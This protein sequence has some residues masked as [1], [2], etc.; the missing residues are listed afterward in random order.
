MM[1]ICFFIGH[2]AFADVT[3]DFTADQTTI[4]AGTE[5]Q[6]TD[7]SIGNP[8]SWQWD[9]ENDG[10]IDSYEQNPEWTYEEPGLFT[11]SLTVSD[12]T[13]SDTETKTD[14]I[15]VRVNIPDANFKAKI[16]S[17]LGQPP[18]YNPTVADLNGITGYFFAGNSNISSIEGVQYLTNIPKLFLNKNQ[19]SDISA[20]SGLTNLISLD[21]EENQII[22]ISA[23]S[24]LTNLTSL[25]LDKNQ[26]SDISAISGLT[27]LSNLYLNDNQISDIS[28]ISGL[29]NLFG[30]SLYYNQ[31]SDISVIS[32]LTNLVSLYLGGNQISDISAI[33]GLTNLRLLYLA[34]NQ[35][36]DISAVS[37]LTNLEWLWL[38]QNQISDIS[39]V[40][41]LMNL[42]YLYLNENQISDISAVSGLTN[43]NFLFLNSN[44][45]SD[46]SAFS[47]LTNLAS[48]YLYNNQISD[49]SVV[50]GLTNLTCF[51]LSNN[52]ISDISTVSGLTNLFFIDLSY[53]QIND[54]SA[55]SSLPNMKKL[56]LGGN[57]IID[58]ATISSLTNLTELSLGGNHISDISAVSG[59]TNLRE[60][61]LDSN[62]ISDIYPLVE[63]TELGSGD[64]LQL[65]SNPL[66]LE[67]LIVHIPI[68]EN[69]GF[70]TLQFPSTPN[71][72][73]ACYPDPARYEVGVSINADLEWQGNFPSRDAV[74]DVWLGETSDDLVNVG[75][76]TAI[77]DTLYSFTP[78]L[79]PDTVYW[80]K[81][82]AI[83]ATD[84]I[85]SGLWRFTTYIIADFSADQT[86]IVAGD[87]IQFTDLSTG[88]PTNWEWDFEN[89][90]IIDSY[91]QNPEWI[92]TE[93]GIYSVSL[94]VS[95]GIYT[96]TKLKEN[97]IIVHE[98]Q[99]PY[100]VSLTS[101]IKEITLEW[102][103]IP[104]NKTNHFNFVGGAIMYPK[105]T[106]YIGGATF[107]GIDM[108]AS[109]EI[110]VFDGDLLVGAFTLDQVCTPYN[111]FENDMTAFSLIATGPGYQA[112]N[113]FTMVAWDESAQVESTSFEYTFSDPY[114]DAYTGDVFP[115]G[116]GEYSVAEF[117]FN[118]YIPVFNIYYEDGTLVAGEVEGATYTDIDLTAGQEYCYYVTQILDNGEESNPSNVLCATPLSD[119]AP[120]L[121]SA[122]PGIEEINLE[123]EPI[124]NKSNNDNKTGHFNF[125][126]FESPWHIW[127]I[128]IS[129]ATFNGID[130]E[131]GDEIG[132]FDGEFLVGDFTLLQICTPDNQFDNDLLAYAYFGLYNIDTVYNPG[133]PFRLVAWDESAQIE[134]TSFE[135]TFSNP[136][137]DAYTDDV[138]P[139]EDG[140]YSMAEFAFTYYVPTF[141]I[142]YEDGTLVAGEIEGTTY[143]D[144]ELI[145]GQEY[146]YYVTQILENGEESDPSNILCG[147]PFHNFGSQNYT[148]E[149]GFQFIS[150]RVIPENPNMMIVLDSVLNENLDLVRNSLGQTL[151]KIGPNW[152]NGI[153]D[154]IV[155]EGYLFKMNSNDSFTI[156]GIFIEPT[157]PIPVESG[158]QFISYFHYIPIDALQA[159]E[160]II[161]DDLEFIR[162]SQGQTLRMIG[163]NW[164]NGIGDCQPGEG[165][166][167]KMLADGV[168]I[169][170][171]SFTCGDVFIDPR[172]EQT[173]NTVK[174]DEQCWMAE[175]LNIGE[176]I[177]G[178]ENM[179]DNGVIEKYCYDDNPTY[180]ETYGGL[181]QW[182]EMMQYVTDTAVQGICPEGWHLPTDFEWK[183]LE[184]RV[185]SQYPVGDPIWNQVG[186]RGFNVGLNLKSIN[187][188]LGGGNGSGFY[189]FGGRPGGYRSNYINLFF[190][191]LSH[192]GY[193]WSSSEYNSSSTWFRSLIYYSDEVFRTFLNKSFGFSVR[194]LHEYL[195]TP[196]E[197]FSI[198]DKN[199]SNNLADQKRK[200]KEAVHFVF[201]GGN[202]AEAV[203][204]LYIKGLGI[205]DEVA[206]FDRDK[207]VGATRIIS[208]NPFENELPV[209]STLTNGTGYEKGNPIILK[210]W[211]ENNIVS[212]DF[213]ID[214]M[215]DSYVSD[216]YP[217][218][219]GK[220]SVVN[221]T[222]G[223][224]ENSKE[225]FSVYPNPTTGIITVG[226]LE[227]FKNLQGIE[228]TDIA[229][230]IVF[231]VEIINQKSKMEIDLSML[232]KGIYFISLSGR[233]FKD[234]KK[235]VI[236]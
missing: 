120:V 95:K 174:I 23:V 205:G 107:D 67:A 170:P 70:D 96:D 79:N 148:L 46:I 233:D 178:S 224:N 132:I 33:S 39:A 88:N 31:I 37:G 57:Q 85:W 176:I 62:Q 229:G 24:D 210:V 126:G 151:R 201:K 90:G 164:V 204:S 208:Q 73:A 84:T 231:Q 41:G 156:N 49:I 184:G 22:D 218:G 78:A 128:Y 80:W 10:T 76:G 223:L 59:L 109:D 48:L 147:P 163:P 189:G 236:Q 20:V 60:L 179:T 180:C 200:S 112:G 198:K 118:Y 154:W 47:G 116:D 75:Y 86:T 185:D 158:F 3:A 27:D 119:N 206:V 64:I 21:L 13:T 25:D 42:S 115:Y 17:R 61:S 65:Y 110:G 127:A 35:I 138:F 194:C 172:D 91:E 155:D 140:E 56:Y 207:I 68:L 153:G 145:A 113:T 36:S 157:T 227:G 14:Y 6:F 159:F 52:Q 19:I 12:G 55:I 121:V 8:T 181:Y 191:S 142:Y 40:S 18:T 209:F 230:K 63:N 2:S 9:F 197:N 15:D 97:Y 228:I 30:L 234:V 28:A 4:V 7:L 87:T 219:D 183:I 193:F 83:T 53:N 104:E 235:I 11:V 187:G 123:W 144:T 81:V 232:E 226:N 166:L 175:N 124:S 136:Y 106:I 98:P 214:A 137:G 192:Y 122:T 225:T 171:A 160:T 195:Q 50:S 168:L 190:L 72:Y 135:Y 69:R 217:E 51:Y 117:S 221:I 186:F 182:N 199:V 103:A 45:I 150:S 146:C 165:Y 134:S 102:E 125:E 38:N 131:P 129:S 94:T 196:Y 93:A 34:G 212:T 220:Y 114:G 26:I 161:S 216:V 5:I 74:Y 92:Y 169:Y 99:T 203:Y 77:N 215:Y 16:N 29:T 101:G 54:I 43:L 141:N 177:G 143:T 58:I 130:M 213:T 32:D 108:E 149:T 167:V 139:Y 202:P 82:R 152:V 100:L 111:Q 222:K 1:M 66:S 71:N 105:W 133:N 173:Y 211:S 162:N 44:Q 89:D 188:W